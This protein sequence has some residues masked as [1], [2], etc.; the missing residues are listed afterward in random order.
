MNNTIAAIGTP[1]TALPTAI[2]G[3][4]RLPGMHHPHRTIDHR[5]CQ[6][7]R[8]EAVGQGLSAEA[9]ALADVEHQGEQDQAEEDDDGGVHGCTC[10]LCGA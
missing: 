7:Q 10:G 1:N 4:Q 9:D 5:Q 2:F 3:S 6:P 8:G